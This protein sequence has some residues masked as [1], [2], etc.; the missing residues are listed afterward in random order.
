MRKYLIG[1][2]ILLLADLLW[3]NVIMK[4]PYDTMI[5]KI[6]K[7]GMK[8]NM[9]SALLAYLAMIIILNYIIIRKNLSLKETFILAACVYAVYDFTA[10]AVF[11]EWNFQLAVLDVIWGGT[12][13]TIAKYVVDKL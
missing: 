8:V 4:K 2:I 1:S 10:G 7:S 13:F 6:Q 3:I 9:V 5:R 12:V 11:K